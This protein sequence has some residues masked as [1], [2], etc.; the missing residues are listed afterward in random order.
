MSSVVIAIL[1]GFNCLQDQR[2]LAML[3]QAVSTN[4]TSAVANKTL[5]TEESWQSSRSG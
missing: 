1:S 4:L 2:V 5:L 3:K